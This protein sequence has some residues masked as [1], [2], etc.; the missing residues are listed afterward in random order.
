MVDHIISCLKKNKY[1]LKSI[2]F[3]K[4][5]DASHCANKILLNL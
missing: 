3:T 4:L 5:T 2:P 1:K